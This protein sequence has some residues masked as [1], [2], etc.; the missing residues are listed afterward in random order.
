MIHPRSVLI[1]GASSGIGAALAKAYASHDR[2][3]VLTGRDDERLALVVSFCREKGAHTFGIL[4][5]QQDIEGFLKVLS[6]LDSEHRFDLVIF[7][8]GI[9]DTRDDIHPFEAPQQIERLIE[10]NLRAPAAGAS[11]IADRMVMRGK[12]SLAFVSSV[13]AFIPLPMAAGYAAS[14]AGLN[15]FA[16]SL[17]A[18]VRKHGISVTLVCPGYVD[19]PM[20]ARLKTS[21]PFQMTPDAAARAIVACIERRQ[22][23][24]IIPTPFAIACYALKLIPVRLAVWLAS[25]SRLKV[26]QYRAADPFNGEGIS[27]ASA[28]PSR[29]TDL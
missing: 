11:L 13:A 15:A 22:V 4:Q 5:D 19:T 20:S 17:S 8:A 18:A 6:D 21:K 9:G 3:L 24:S 10:I 23:F 28:V 27:N 14:K 25:L 2:V 26:V 7:N 29:N 12:G 16:L 1:T